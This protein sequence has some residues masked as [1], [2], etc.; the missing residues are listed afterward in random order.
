MSSSLA[1]IG[2]YIILVIQLPVMASLSVFCR[3]KQ[4][5]DGKDGV[6][7]TKDA[8]KE[9]SRSKSRQWGHQPRPPPNVP[10]APPPK[11]PL[12]DTLSI[13]AWRTPPLAS[14]LG[15]GNPRLYMGTFLS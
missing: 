8:P 5:N 1:S 4:N 9:G 2:S 15:N 7:L 10:I 12:D 3:R 6:V 11:D 13:E 14:Q